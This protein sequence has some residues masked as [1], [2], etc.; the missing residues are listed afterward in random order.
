MRTL[1]VEPSSRLRPFV[2]AISYS[3]PSTGPT[4]R[5]LVLPD[6]SAV[7]LWFNLNRDEFVTYERDA[8]GQRLTTGGAVAAGPSD[9]SS[10]IEI[11]ANRSHVCVDFV[12]GAAPAL[13]GGTV[14]AFRNQLV[15]LNHGWT[16]AGSLRER[17]LEAR[18]PASMLT[19]IDTLLVDHLTQP[20]VDG[21]AR[22]AARLLDRGV[23]VAAVADTIGLTTRTLLRRFTNAFG[24]TP[25]RFA[26]V[27][28]LKRLVA[29]IGDE[30]DVDWAHLAAT[31][32]FADQPHLADEFR[33]LVGVRPTAYLANRRSGPAHVAVA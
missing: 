25:K 14:A 29:S 2:R 19:L 13:L 21:A 20:T 11:E 10:I 1:V 27:Q 17:L 4:L 15:D 3:P 6:A 12:P 28:R 23:P 18:S 33:D 9:R 32:D 8:P 24:V 22:E 30:T 5:D 16:D 7:S 26:R 31:H